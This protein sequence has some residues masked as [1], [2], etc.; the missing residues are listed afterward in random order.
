[1]RL[2]RSN[3]R[4]LQQW[5][6]RAF[7]SRLSSKMSHIREL[8]VSRLV[9]V[10][11]AICTAGKS[12]PTPTR[13]GAETYIALIRRG[14]YDYHFGSRLYF[15]DTSTAFIYD[16]GAEYRA[17][18]PT[19]GGDDI[20]K[21]QVAPE[22]MAELFSARRPNEHVQFNLTPATQLG[23]FRT[24]A[25]LNGGG[26]EALGMEEVVLGL[27]NQLTANP[28]PVANCT[29]QRRLVDRA[30]AIL[31]EH[32]ERNLDLTA[33]AEEVG[34]SPYHLMRIFRGQT[35]QA[36]RGYRVRLRMIAALDRLAQ[37]ADDITALALD[38]GFSSHSHMTDAF[39][40]VFHLAPSQLRE[41]LAR[42]GL[43]DRRR[44]LEAQVRSAA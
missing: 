8:Y 17:S 30:K 31:S 39:R 38:V 9:A 26:G 3:G 20:T 40:A 34:C 35:G 14:C 12:G 2:K 32:L 29:R 5:L 6:S 13:G 16:A 11:D 25:M 21:V 22:L 7:R 23:H 19:D 24:Y 43:D 37:G 1:M 41:Q 44:F 10:N 42:G 28:I 33:V 15:A 27:L 18:H 4:R 36:L